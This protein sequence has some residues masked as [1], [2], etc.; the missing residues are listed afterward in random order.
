MG[1]RLRIV[2]NDSRLIYEFVQMLFCFT[3]L[4]DFISIRLGAICC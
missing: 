3:L 1:Y 4:F 2:Q